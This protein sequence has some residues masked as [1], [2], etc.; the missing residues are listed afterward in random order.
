[1]NWMMGLDLNRENALDLVQRDGQPVPE[2]RD[3]Q[4][5]FDG[6]KIEFDRKE[7]RLQIWKD[8]RNFYIGYIM[9]HSNGTIYLRAKKKQVTARFERD[10]CTAALCREF[11]LREVRYLDPSRQ[12]PQHFQAG[13]L[14]L[15]LRWVH[16][17]TPV[18]YTA[19]DGRMHTFA[20]GPEL[21]ADLTADHQE[22]QPCPSVGWVVADYY[23]DGDPERPY[24]ILY[25]VEKRYF[26]IGSSLRNYCKDIATRNPGLLWNG[27]NARGKFSSQP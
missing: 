9:I 4:L 7:Q 12:Y 10:N 17:S 13:D 18:T 22:F 5:V 19:T 20:Y 1:M 3:N 11:S 15:Q 26:A 23:V 25:T 27:A 24:P 6:W 21:P 14:R 2:N 8:D 16:S